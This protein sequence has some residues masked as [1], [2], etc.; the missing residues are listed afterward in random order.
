MIEVVDTPPNTARSRAE[1][2]EELW[3]TI[4]KANL[5]VPAH[6]KV[7]KDHVVFVRSDKPMASAGK[8]SVMRQATLK[9]YAEELKDLYD[10]ANNLNSFSTPLRD[11]HSVDIGNEANL[12]I[13]ISEM[14]EEATEWKNL[15]QE[16]DLFAMG[17]GSLQ[18]IHLTR[19]LRARLRSLHI[20][21]NTVYLHSSLNALAKGI[22][23]MASEDENDRNHT[24]ESYRKLVSSTL[25][26]YVSR[27]DT[28]AGNLT[29]RS[30]DDD[31]NLKEVGICIMLTGSSELVGSYILDALLRAPS[32]SR[33]YCFNHLHQKMHIQG[34]S[35]RVEVHELHN[36]PK[37]TMLSGKLSEPNFGLKES[38]FQILQD[39]ISLVI[40]AAWNENFDLTL[41]AFDSQLE[42]IVRLVEFSQ[43]AARSPMIFFMSSISSI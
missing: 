24:K 34:N 22:K 5:E 11:E 12:H 42:G 28:I 10:D 17:M 7:T 25:E 38:D 21:I 31:T 39:S 19:Q 20:N 3:P 1:A 27:V 30:E 15:D 23:M 29:R 2:I 14:V 35:A 36:H 8:G 9:L 18:A 26:S 37:T 32:T 6:T 41:S 16:A 33:V 13:A 4:S 43:L 40:H